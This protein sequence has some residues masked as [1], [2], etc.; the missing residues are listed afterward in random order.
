VDA[1]LLNMITFKKPLPAA[2]KPTPTD[3]FHTSLAIFS[4]KTFYRH[5][6]L[7]VFAPFHGLDPSLCRSRAKVFL[8]KRFIAPIYI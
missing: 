8:K 7:H 1:G 2:I 6:Q 3:N 4:H 5:Q